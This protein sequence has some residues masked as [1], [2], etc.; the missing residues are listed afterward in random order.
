MG[1]GGQ[2]RVDSLN[3]LPNP[4]LV[5]VPQFHGTEEIVMLCIFGKKKKTSRKQTNKHTVWVLET[6]CSK[7][8]KKYLLKDLFPSHLPE[9]IR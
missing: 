2:I 1:V 7:R 3:L 6:M 5:Q 9:G 4:M 8:E